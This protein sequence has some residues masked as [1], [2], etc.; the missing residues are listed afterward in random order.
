[1]QLNERIPNNV[2][3]T[4]NKRLLRALEH[5][6]PAYLDWWRDMGPQGFQDHH[7][8]YLRTA[9]SVDAAGW[10]HFDYVKLPDYRWGIFLAEPTP[11]RRIGFGDFKGNPVWQEV[12]GEFRNQLRR[13]IVLQGDEDA[14]VPPAQS[15]AIV[16]ALR[17]KGVPVAYLLFAGEQHGFRRAENV[18]R[19]IDAELSFYAQV[20]GFPHD[21][22]IEPVEVENLP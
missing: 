3:L 15:E 9:V 16:A 1:M 5:W 6:Q 10:A 2:D 13:L 7:Q 4:G 11:D 17:E 12:P 19:A 8:V 22:G 20:L 18:R 14:I 21:E